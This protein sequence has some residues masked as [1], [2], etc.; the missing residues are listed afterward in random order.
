MAT[1]TAAAPHRATAVRISMVLLAILLAS[2]SI[3]TTSR[4]VFTDT[5]DNNGNNQWDLGDIPVG[6]SG[7]VVIL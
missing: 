1:Q 4:A 5:T 3:L 6:G 7:Q 2:F